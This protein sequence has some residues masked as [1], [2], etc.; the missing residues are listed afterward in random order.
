MFSASVVTEKSLE[1]VEQLLPAAAHIL[2]NKRNW[3]CQKPSLATSAFTACV[4]SQAQ[5]QK[6]FWYYS[7]T[8]LLCFNND[9][10]I[11]H[12]RWQNE[13]ILQYL[14]SLNWVSAVEM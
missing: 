13:G 14:E 4:S 6:L 8:E 9:D 2:C 11:S 3:K 5:P 10:N 12:L 1:A 7:K